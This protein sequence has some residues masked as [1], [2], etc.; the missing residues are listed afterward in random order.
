MRRVL[1]TLLTVALLIQAAPSL[2]S[3]DYRDFGWDPEDSG[4]GFLDIRTSERKVWTR[5]RTVPV[6]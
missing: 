5:G 4:G 1:M 6:G 3:R 2:A